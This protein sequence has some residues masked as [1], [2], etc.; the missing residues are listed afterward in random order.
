MGVVQSST[1]HFPA[2]EETLLSEVRILSGIASAL[3]PEYK[4]VFARYEADYDSIRDDIES[5][6]PGFENYNKRVRK[7][8]G[9]YLP[10]GPRDREF[11]TPVGKARFT[12]NARIDQRLEEGMLMLQTFRTHDQYNTTVYG[13]ED[14]YRGVYYDRWVILMNHNDM[15]QRGIKPLSKVNVTSHYEEEVRE[16]KAVTAIPYSMPSGACAAY[17]PEANVLVPLTKTAKI[18]NTPTSKSIPVRVE[19]LEEN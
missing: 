8:G 13:M 17:F 2:V 11:S 4:G 1:G 9:F 7:D 3:L 6:I 15:Q 18:S 10:N 14:R 19:V 5:V 16:M 12:A